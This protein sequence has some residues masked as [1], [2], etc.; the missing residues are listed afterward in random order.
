MGYIDKL[1]KYNKDLLDYLLGRLVQ[2][3]FN[4]A[5]ISALLAITSTEN[6]F[7]LRPEECYNNTKTSYI[8]TIGFKRLKGKSDQFIDDLKKDCVK[9]F[10]FVYSNMLGN[11]LNDGY[12]YRGRGFHQLTGKGQYEDFQKYTNSD[13]VNNPDNVNKKEVAS[14]L[15]IAYF[16]TG[17][18]FYDDAGATLK[19]YGQKWSDVKDSLTAY[20]IAGNINAGWGNNPSGRP[21]YRLAVSRLPEFDEYVKKKRVV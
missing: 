1:P 15:I 4:N 11:G 21:A 20:K 17:G 13:I 12:K 14:D 10:D 5:Q 3:K 19:R 2:A 8:K 7:S 9:F 18:K 16:R 6:G